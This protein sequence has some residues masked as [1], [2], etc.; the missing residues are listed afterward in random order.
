MTLALPQ[1][2][3]TNASESVSVS[4]PHSGAEPRISSPPQNSAAQVD[5]DWHFVGD[6]ALVVRPTEALAQ[7]LHKVFQYTAVPT[8]VVVGI[9]VLLLFMEA[10]IEAHI[11]GRVLATYCAAMCVVMTG[12]LMYLHL[13]AYTDPVQQRRI[14][15]ILMMVPIYAIDSCLA[16]WS[17]KWA[18]VIGLMRD[19]Y[20]SYVIYTFFNLLMGY[21]GGEDSA[22]AAK[23]GTV[24]HHLTPCCCLK[25]FILTRRTFRTW[26]FLLAQ[27]VVV[28]PFMSFLAILLLLMGEYD[29]SS[30]SFKGSH[31]YCVL[32][33]NTSVT[34]AFTCLV[35]FF[36]QYRELLK[37][38]RPLGK[39]AAVK[40]VVFLSFWQSVLLGILVEVGVIKGSREGLWS[41]DEVSTGVQDFLICIEMLG[42]C[43]A[44]H[45]VFPDTPYVPV[46]GHHNLASWIVVHAFSLRDVLH[47][48]F[49]AVAGPIMNKGTSGDQE[50][51]KEM[52]ETAPAELPVVGPGDDT[53]AKRK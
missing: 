10:K 34:L 2:E 6:D 3:G 43:Y 40:A 45:Y 27:Y 38:H 8:A 44:H 29:E 39:F 37:E 28:K 19:C 51:P 9:L 32:V 13:T 1:G 17:Y 4:S 22:L 5:A 12:L 18:P 35:Y 20:E 21:M 14:L 50:K 52:R 23:C 31:I 53:T 26:K 7:R 16:L 15:R 42:M 30:W 36:V 49:S 47:E 48:T 24:V 33:V 46:T 41:P 11:V 25:G